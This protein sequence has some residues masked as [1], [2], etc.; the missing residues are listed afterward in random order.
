MK[1]FQIL[2]DDEIIY[3]GTFSEVP[4]HY[5]E[6]LVSCLEEWSDVLGKKSINELIYSSFYWYK[7]QKMYCCNCCVFIEQGSECTDCGQQLEN[8]FIHD[9]NTDVDRIFDCIGM[10]TSIEV[11]E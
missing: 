6:N 3:E 8:K 1:K 4:D 9:R 10:I 7:Q 5:R 11:I 2:V